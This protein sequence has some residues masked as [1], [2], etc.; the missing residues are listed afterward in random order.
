MYNSA[1]IVQVILWTL[2]ISILLG[3]AFYPSFK[4]QVWGR[5]KLLK[6]ARFVLMPMTL[7]FLHIEFLDSISIKENTKILLGFQLVGACL[8]LFSLDRNLAALGKG[9]VRE[10]VGNWF[11]MVIFGKG[12]APPNYIV[13]IFRGRR[14]E[15]AY[16]A[17]AERAEE[18]CQLLDGITAQ[19]E[20]LNQIFRRNLGEQ[21]RALKELE[22]RM[23]LK[24]RDLEQRERR[25]SD[26]LYRVRIESLKVQLSGAFLLVYGVIG[27]QL[28]SC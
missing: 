2:G 8:V 11:W 26:T 19:S 25:T 27:A 10:V 14:R 15:S 22:D 6:R 3:C 18:S 1:D 23:L 13:R 24:F 5:L 9:S 4:K 28:L 7:V 20:S 12:S 17:A 21:E 16:R